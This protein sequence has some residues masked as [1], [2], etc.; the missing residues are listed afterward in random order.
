M[1]MTTEMML[2]L[3]MPLFKGHWYKTVD[4][5]CAS[6]SIIFG[7]TLNEVNAAGQL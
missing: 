2:T 7:I 3:M 1:T 4:I 6:I 5:Y